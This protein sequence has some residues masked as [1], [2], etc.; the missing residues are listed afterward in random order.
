MD[1]V[2]AK[3]AVYKVVEIGQCRLYTLPHWDNLNNVRFLDSLLD[4]EDP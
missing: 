4:Q 1:S 3:D 2:G